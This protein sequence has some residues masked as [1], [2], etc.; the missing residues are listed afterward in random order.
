MISQDV[1]YIRVVQVPTP[2]VGT[3]WSVA[4]P[5]QGLWRL[6]AFRYVFTTDANV[7][8]RLPSLI[9]D[10]GTSA[11]LQVSAPAVQAAGI[12]QSYSGFPG[13]G[14]A[15]LAGAPWL[16]P[17]PS[18]GILLLPGFRLRS[19]T[20]AIQVGDQFSAIALYIEELPT[21]PAVRVTPT[22]ATITTEKA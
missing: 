5:G 1:Q 12:A 10:D 14:G 13:S 19:S 22:V 11:L 16:V 8:N 21:G 3:D 20:T 18:D 9:V 7:A 6:L 17:C 4:A 15:A 2:A